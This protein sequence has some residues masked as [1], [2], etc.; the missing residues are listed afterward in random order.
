MNTSYEFQIQWES[1]NWDTVMYS[2]NCSDMEIKMN[3]TSIKNRF[4][5]RR[6]RCVTG[7]GR[8]VDMI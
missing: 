4:S 2:D 7:D 3:M 6:T 1:G 8:L 5:G